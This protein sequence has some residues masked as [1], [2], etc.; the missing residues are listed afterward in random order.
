MEDRTELHSYVLITPDDFN[1]SRRIPVTAGKA[2]QTPPEEEEAIFRVED[3]FVTTPPLRSGGDFQ[4]VIVR[5]AEGQPT[6]LVCG[7]TGGRRSN[8]VEPGKSFTITGP[9]R[10]HCCGVDLKYG[11]IPSTPGSSTEAEEQ[12][13]T[14]MQ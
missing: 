10:S 12:V 8:V 11:G 13:V 2:T 14:V 9:A 5:H 6:G 1:K 7:G 4:E 3:T